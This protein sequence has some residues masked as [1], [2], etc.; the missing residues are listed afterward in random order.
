MRFSSIV[1]VVAPDEFCYRVEVVGDD[2][3]AGGDLEGLPDHGPVVE[4]GVVD[5]EVKEDHS[6]AGA[7]P[8]VPLQLSHHELRGRLVL[9]EN[10]RVAVP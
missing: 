3:A 7:Q 9:P 8:E 6:S 5:G 2:S 1:V 4:V 10:L